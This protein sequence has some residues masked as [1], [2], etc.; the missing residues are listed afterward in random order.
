MGFLPLEPSSC[1]GL[2]WPVATRWHHRP[3]PLEPPTSWYLR[4]LGFWLC[5]NPVPPRPDRGEQGGRLGLPV[6]YTGAGSLVLGPT[7]HRVLLQY[8]HHCRFYIWYHL[9]YDHRP[10]RPSRAAWCSDVVGWGTT[11]LLGPLYDRAPQR[12]TLCHLVLALGRR[13]LDLCLRGLLH[14]G[15]GPVNPPLGLVPSSRA[16]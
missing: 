11:G 3:I 10:P 14:M 12:P 15:G 1:Y 5:P 7:S 2:G 13:G 8:L 6:P 9:L 4:A 16:S